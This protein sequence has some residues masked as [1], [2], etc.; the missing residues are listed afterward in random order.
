MYDIRVTMSN[1]R[2]HGF[3]EDKEKE[4]QESKFKPESLKR[5]LKAEI[6]S[7]EEKAKEYEKQVGEAKNMLDKV[8]PKEAQ[9]YGAP[10]EWLKP[11]E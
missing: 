10:P 4:L 2:S 7:L 5:R 11:K 6:E 9:D 8:L 1:K 3:L